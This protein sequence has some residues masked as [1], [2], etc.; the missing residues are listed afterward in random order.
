MRDALGPRVTCS[1]TLRVGVSVP[2][3]LLSSRDVVVSALPSGP[4]ATILRQC[5][6]EPKVPGP[7]RAV[8]VRGAATL[9]RDARARRFG[10]STRDATFSL[11]RGCGAPGVDDK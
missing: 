11:E 4:P 3:L 8:T 5:A 10:A 6:A 9:P 1:P 2:A 7:F